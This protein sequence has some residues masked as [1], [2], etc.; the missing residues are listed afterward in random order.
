MIWWIPP[1]C[2]VSSLEIVGTVNRPEPHTRSPP[3]VLLAS[4]VGHSIKRTCSWC[5]LL[6]FKTHK[7]NIMERYPETVVSPSPVHLDGKQHVSSKNDKQSIATPGTRRVNGT[8]VKFMLW[9]PSSWSFILRKCPDSL[10]LFSKSW[11]RWSLLESW[12][13]QYVEVFVW[14]LGRCC[15]NFPDLGKS[16]S[17]PI[18]LAPKKRCIANIW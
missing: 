17:P 12:S 2:I 8:W 5:S 14:L 1:G 3:S 13:C 7:N 9:I 10:S 16:L 11:N 15:Q 18:L 4:T 6:N